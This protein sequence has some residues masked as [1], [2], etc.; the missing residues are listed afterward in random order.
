MGVMTAACCYEH[1]LALCKHQ[2][3]SGY[4]VSCKLDTVIIILLSAQLIS[5]MITNPF[6]WS[7]LFN[8]YIDYYV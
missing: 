2:H 4:G 7:W 1:G 6:R 8:K 5:M 3:A